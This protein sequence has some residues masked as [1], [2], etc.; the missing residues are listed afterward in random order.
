MSVIIYVH[1][2]GDFVM[3]NKYI[4]H[5]YVFL[6]VL[7]GCYSNE[8]VPCKIPEYFITER[9]RSLNVDSVAVWHGE[10]DQHWLVATAKSTHNLPVYDAV[11]GE[12]IKI[13]G[14]P[15]VKAGQ[16]QRPNGIAIEDDLI[17]IVERD[18]KRLHILALPDGNALGYTDE[19]MQRPYGL[20]VV[21]Q[22]PYKKY[23]VY[24]TDNYG[25]VDQFYPKKVHQY[26]VERNG[27]D[28]NMQFIRTFGDD[29]GKGALWKL[30]SIAVD[31][32]HDR[33]FIADEHEQ[34]KNVKIYTLDGEFTGQTIGDGLIEY[35]PEGIALYETTPEHGYVIVTDQDRD[36]NQFYLFNRSSLVSIK[37][38]KGASVC[39]TDGIAI[40]NR[41]FGPFKSGAFYA[42]HDDGNIC[43]YDWHLLATLC[44][45]GEKK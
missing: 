45:L 40:T 5:S 1:I 19:S 8:Y 22:E 26:A 42:V 17:F 6:I 33:L 29:A 43:A 31:P 27:D 11:T 10:N 14:E 34:Q 18:N 3:L 28:V 30:E 20:A 24:V 21:V 13:I 36:G 7:S 39:N 38:F 41:S 4:K 15:G 9:D 12:L 35:E 32:F 2:K 16:F 25:P 23:I 37:A 44:G